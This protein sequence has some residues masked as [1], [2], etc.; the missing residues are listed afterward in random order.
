[1]ATPEEQE[2]EISEMSAVECDPIEK[3]ELPPFAYA[4]RLRH[5]IEKSRVSV[6][7]HLAHLEK[8][9]RDDTLARE[10]LPKLVDIENTIEN[11]IR[12]SANA[13]PVWTQW[14][15]HMRRASPLLV[16]AVLSRADITRLHTVSSMWAHYG[17]APGQKRLPGLKITYDAI[18]RTW[19][20]RLG[21][22]LL[23]TSPRFQAVYHQRKDYLTQRVLAVGGKI[24]PQKKGQKVLEPNLGALHL[25]NDALRYMIKTW[26]ACAYIVWRRAE[27]LSI[28]EPYAMAHLGHAPEHKYQPEDFVDHQP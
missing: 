23:K 6:Q 26:L 9:K 3:E 17:F 5:F 18:G 25:H 21:D 11:S 20:W 28:V 7:V 27:G 16:G 8:R 22:Y 14:A 24:E 10:V 13:H 1:M 4:G 12:A 19:C 2:K 15:S